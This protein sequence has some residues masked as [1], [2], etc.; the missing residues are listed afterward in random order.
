MADKSK[1]KFKF[2]LVYEASKK[3]MPDIQNDNYSKITGIKGYKPLK[4]KV[5]A[6]LDSRKW[7][8]E[9][10]IKEEAYYGFK[11]A[12]IMLDKDIKKAKNDKDYKD[13][14]DTFLDDA[15][16]GLDK[17]M[18]DQESGKADNAKAMKDGK[19]AMNKLNN[20]KFKGAFEGP[21]KAAL[22]AL[23]PLTKS[24]PDKGA[25]KKA[26]DALGKIK[27]GFDA[28]GKEGQNVIDFLTK[29]AKTQVKDDK[30]DPEVKKFFE[31]ALKLEDKLA[32]VG[33][34]VEEFADALDQAIEAVKAS[35]PDPDAIKEAY[36]T[37]D[38]LSSLEADAI[39]ALDEAKK[40]VPK[41]KKIEKKFT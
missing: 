17:W 31:E 13:A 7:K 27:T 4:Y 24:S 26:A 40:L 21:R 35:E 23:K 14:W 3:D 15:E 10:K 2:D 18:K 41:F 28:V 1:K 32:P 11:M 20:M 6:E 5:D 38:G 19:S 12:V 37:L 39:K 9:A 22:E 29:T 36:D 25:G 34:S 33:E 16:Y 8:N 30:I